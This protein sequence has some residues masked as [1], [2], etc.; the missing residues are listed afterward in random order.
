MEYLD[1]MVK[2]LGMAHLWVLYGTGTGTVWYRTSVRYGTD[3]LVPMENAWYTYLT[4]WYE[5][6]G[7]SRTP[8]G[9]TSG[10]THIRAPFDP[11]I[12]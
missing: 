3:N 7:N 5:Y 10:K 6:D 4:K 11:I 1:A 2:Y 9:S 12:P 8:T